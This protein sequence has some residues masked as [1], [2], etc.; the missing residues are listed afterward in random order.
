MD[1][2]RCKAWLRLCDSSTQSISGDG[3]KFFKVQFV[4]KTT[5]VPT[6]TSQSSFEDIQCHALHNISMDKMMDENTFVSWL[7]QVNVP[8][9]AFTMVVEAIMQC[10]SDIVD[11]ETYKNLKFL[12]IRVDFSVKRAIEYVDCE[13]EEEEENNSLE[14]DVE[15]IDVE[16]EEDNG[17]VDDVTIIE[18]ESDEDEHGLEEDEEEPMMLEEEAARFIPANEYHC[19]AWLRKSDSNTQRISCDDKKYFDIQFEYKTRH[20]S[21]DMFQS[22]VEHIQRDALRNISMDKMMDENTFV[23][24]LSLINVPQDAFTL[25]IEEIMQVASDA[26]DDERKHLTIRVDFSVTMAIEDEEEEIMVEEEYTRFIPA[27]KS[28][29]EELKMVKV[30]EVT[31]CTICLEG[32]NVGVPLPC[33]HMFHKNCIEDWLVIGHCCPLCRFELPTSNTR[34]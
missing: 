21:T 12:T 15:I 17:L 14:E 34:E 11:D 13:E 9:D 32:V 33:S 27:D 23:S 29:I 4:Y 26:V 31:K 5:Y 25:V 24:W 2:Y 10:A 16:E 19:K 20:V 18:I 8:Q 7:S 1:E 28:C 6:D 3:N 22:S 30:E